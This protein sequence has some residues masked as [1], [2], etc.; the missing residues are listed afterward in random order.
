MTVGKDAVIKD[1]VVM[2]GAVIGEG[3]VI[4]KSVIG[5]NAVIGADAKI[6]VN[7]ESEDNPYKSKYCTHGIVLIEGGAAVEAGADILKGSMV[8]A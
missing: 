8:Q 3:A 5:S 1:S 7:H 4:E 6:G 2:P